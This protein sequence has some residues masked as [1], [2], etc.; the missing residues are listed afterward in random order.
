[1]VAPWRN[2]TYNTPPNSLGA[3]TSKHR[4]AKRTQHTPMKTQGQVRK[5]CTIPPVVHPS[6]YFTSLLARGR[7]RPTTVR[8][9]NDLVPKIP[10]DRGYI[11]GNVLRHVTPPLLAVPTQFSNSTTYTTSWQKKKIQITTTR[12]SKRSAWNERGLEKKQTLRVI[13]QLGWIDCSIS[14]VWKRR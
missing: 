14:M 9:A 5:F 11:L 13:A 1:M 10:A 7:C 12:F 6:T 3:S 8:S 2:T 4:D